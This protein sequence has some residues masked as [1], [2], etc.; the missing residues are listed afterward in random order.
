[1][2]LYRYA[3][4]DLSITNAEAFIQ[5]INADGDGRDSKK[6][7]I[8]YVVLGKSTTWPDEPNPIFP[9]DNEQYLHYEVQRNFIG[10]KKVQSS[11]VSHVAT[12]YDWTSGTVYSM[13]RDTDIDVYYR[14][15]YVVTDENNVYKCLYNNKNA[16]STVKPTGYSLQPFTTSDGYM[17]KYMYT[18]SL[19]E[20]NKFMTPSH[21]PVKTA[22][23]E[24]GSAETDRLLLVQN[25]AVNGSIQVVETF[26]PG[27]NYSQ[28]ANGVVEAGGKY[29]LRLSAIGANPPSPVD[30]FYNGCSVYVISGT[31]AG[32]LRRVINYSG[33][34]K[35]LTVNTAFASVCN[36]DSRVIVSPTVTIVGDGQGAKAYATVN[37]ST[38]GVANIA[39]V[40]V[41][42]GYS[43]A[44]AYITANNV[45]GYGAAANVV[46]S[47]LGGHGSDPVRELAAD[48]VM[49]NVQFSGQEGI[50][51]NGN[52][53]IP[54]NTEFRTISIL[55]D[56]VLKVNSNNEHKTTEH[57][58]NTSNSPATLRFTTRIV[59]SYNEMDEAIPE[60]PFYKGDVLTNKRN[61]LR[62]R[63]GALEFVTE[64]SQLAKD[65][66]ALRNATRSANGQIVYLRKDETEN[67]PSFYTLYINNVNSYSDYAAFTKD[68]VLVKSTSETAV[69]TV[70]SIKGPEA[71]TYSGEVIFTENVQ[72]VTRDISQ[73]EDIKVI[74]DF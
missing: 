38:G 24:D 32:Q 2:G 5:K 43:R 64:L 49:I 52:G 59:S 54:S 70:E 30:N 12:R 68:D 27:A 74:L 8:L 46:V 61:I 45:H 14:K 1:M 53:Y 40:S 58:A 29:S 15:F 33:S 55:A 35:T 36:S 71:N 18:I 69:A 65:N 28:V 63:T 17:W 13:Y 37:P 56:P 67:D 47:P 23:A 4:K 50:S 34:T 41:G 7:S 19:T 6:S 16:A 48:R 57:V 62:A 72:P 3:T 51:A 39:M 31:G 26:K 22:V 11:D 21:I 9:P 10:G 25:T 66:N 42:S 60:N 44:K 20:Q 73:I